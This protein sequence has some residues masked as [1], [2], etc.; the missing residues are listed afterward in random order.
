MGWK[1][2]SSDV[3]REIRVSGPCGEVRDVLSAELDGEAT[4]LEVAAARA[5]LDGCADCRVWLTQIENLQRRVRVRPADLVPDLSTSILEKAH[6]PRPGRGEWVRYSLVVVALT[7]LVIALPDLLA[8]SADQSVHDSR[9]FGAMAV[10]LSLGLLYTAHR[11]IRAYGVLP[12]VAAL[13][14]TMIG[15][16]AVDVIRGS[17]VLLS[18]SVHA[19]EMIG[20]LLV[21]MLAGLPGGR[22]RRVRRV[23]LRRVDSADVAVFRRRNS[24]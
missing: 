13:A 8:V 1:L 23:G 9:H 17:A 11:P 15:A 14:V 4:G 3:S 6:P 2:D 12:I 24:A 21:W 5:H 7:Q 16:A 22:F 18:E 19:L 10:A 20:F